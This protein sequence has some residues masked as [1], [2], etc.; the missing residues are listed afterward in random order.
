[1]RQLFCNFCKSYLRGV[2]FPK[3]AQKPT[4]HLRH[5]GDGLKGEHHDSNANTCQLHQLL[6]HKRHEL[7]EHDPPHDQ[8]DAK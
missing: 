3:E 2:Q 1:M 4:V 8:G 5:H 6:E 7:L